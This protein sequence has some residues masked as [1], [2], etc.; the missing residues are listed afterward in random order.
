MTQTSESFLHRFDTGVSLGAQYARGND[1][2]QYN[3]AWD[4]GYQAV[5]WGAKARYNSNLSSSTGTEAATRNQFDVEGYRLLGRKKYFWAGSAGLLQSSVQGIERQSNLALSLG[6]YL[7]H[8][9]RIQW[10]VL[11]GLGWQR[12]QYEP[13]V[14]L[15]RVQN[16]GVAVFSTTV[17]AY[18]FKKTRVDVSASYLTALTDWGRNFYRTNMS[19]YFKLFGKI[20]WDLSFYG[21]WDTR[22][23]A[24]LPGADYGS[25]TGLRWSFGNRR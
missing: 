25:S 5:R 21:S 4:L 8:S 20:D 15:Q 9:N 2:T 22:P 12:N 3:F 24:N 23:P 14:T 10:T 1:T 7:K 17:D 11:G 18:V 6:R 16:I 19:Y 13:E